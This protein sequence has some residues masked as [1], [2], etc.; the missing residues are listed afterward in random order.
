M[1]N[2]ETPAELGQKLTDL[3]T[4]ILGYANEAFAKAHEAIPA[5]NPKLY[6]SSLH[7]S[8]KFIRMHIDIFERVVNLSEQAF[9]EAVKKGIVRVEKE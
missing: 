1:D 3:S 6:F 9:A 8:I 5:N 7:E 4:D 2:N